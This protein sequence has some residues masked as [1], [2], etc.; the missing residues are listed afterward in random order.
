MEVAF[1]SESLFVAHPIPNQLSFATGVLR[2]LPLTMLRMLP[3]RV[4]A[5]LAISA[6]VRNADRPANLI[7]R[8]TRAN[9]DD[10]LPSL[11][12]HL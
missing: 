2:G 9:G 7:C 5:V 3:G 4:P 12:N 8:L 10:L 11:I 1:M 6:T